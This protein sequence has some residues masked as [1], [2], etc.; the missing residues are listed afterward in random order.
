M[1]YRIECVFKK[2]HRGMFRLGN[3]VI[4]NLGNLMGGLGARLV[5]SAMVWESL[6]PGLLRGCYEPEGF[7]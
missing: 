4:F 1:G 3:L 5:V 7:M 2:W 6:Y